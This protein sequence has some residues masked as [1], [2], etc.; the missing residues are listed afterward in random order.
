MLL[1]SN[2]GRR[3]STT[4][5][6]V[7]SHLSIVSCIPDFC[8]ARQFRIEILIAN[9]DTSFDYEELASSKSLS[10]QNLTVI[11]PKS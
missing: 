9:I 7:S 5:F 1:A 3:S 11:F 10:A 6:R 2:Q 8:P 4:L